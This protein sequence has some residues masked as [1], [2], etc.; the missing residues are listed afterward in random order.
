MYEKQFQLSRRPFQAHASGADVF[1]GPQTA[2]IMASMKKALAAT[3][4]VVALTGEP[5]VG[6]STLV[7]RAIDAI[8]GEKLVIRVA[9]MQL[10]HDEV[11]EFLLD[12]LGA[13]DVPASTIKKINLCRD[14]L[15]QQSAAGTRIFVVIEDAIR[16][17]EDAL[18]EFE[19][20]TATDSDFSTGANIILMGDEPLLDNLKS[21]ALR[22]LKQRTRLRQPVLP[23]SA[24][25]LLGY[26]KHCF[27]LAG[28]EV[29][30]IFAPHGRS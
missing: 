18:A 27:P 8:S 10:G 24:S 22:R 26:L 5:G 28:G 7:N 9:R 21:P 3:D 20:L 12:K 14:L 11:L 13:G 4:A 19:S 6:K 30:L 15:G 29:D 2:K 23:L 16:I 1:V 17:G 25:E